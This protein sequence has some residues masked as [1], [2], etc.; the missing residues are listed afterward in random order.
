MGPT[1]EY[2]RGDRAVRNGRTRDQGTNHVGRQIYELPLAAK[3]PISIAVI[4][5]ASLFLPRQSAGV[6]KAPSAPPLNFQQ[7]IDLH[8][9]NQIVKKASVPHLLLCRE[10]LI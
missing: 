1:S 5:K 10:I 7:F 8:S 3:N 9:L 4:R 6:L 2:Q